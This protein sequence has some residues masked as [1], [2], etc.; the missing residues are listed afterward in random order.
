LL[1]H[2][3][4]QQDVMLTL[5]NKFYSHYEKYM[6]DIVDT[7]VCFFYLGFSNVRS[8]IEVENL[9]RIFYRIKA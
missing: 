7:A 6:V 5:V 2:D 4:Q 3:F 8:T 9:D 1:K